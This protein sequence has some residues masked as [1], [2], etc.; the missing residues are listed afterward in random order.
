MGK[1][2]RLLTD[3]VC[4][5]FYFTFSYCHLGIK[6]CFFCYACIRLT[7][8]IRLIYRVYIDLDSLH[9][10]NSNKIKHI[11]TLYLIICKA[12]DDTG[13]VFFGHTLPWIG[14]Y[15][16]HPLHKFYISEFNPGGLFLI[17]R[18]YGG[19]FCLTPVFFEPSNILST[20]QSIKKPPVKM[21]FN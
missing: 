11:L 10:L 19:L 21:A 20:I 14:T 18:F 6:I 17:F 12:K 3:N 2:G 16:H 4:K 13:G 7:N 5:Y 8:C 9:I 1:N 15:Y